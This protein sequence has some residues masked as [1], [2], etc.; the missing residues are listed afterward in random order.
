MKDTIKTLTLITYITLFSGYEVNAA[1]KPATCSIGDAVIMVNGKYNCMKQGAPVG[2][3]I[4]C[5]KPMLAMPSS[6]GMLVLSTT[7]KPINNI[8]GCSPSFTNGYCAVNC[9]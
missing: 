7:G 9:G 5:G 8:S 6:W 4:G 2:S 1:L 3:P